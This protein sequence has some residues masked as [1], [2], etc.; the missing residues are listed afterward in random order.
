LI[1]PILILVQDVLYRG[2]RLRYFVG[3]SV[4]SAA[5]FLSFSRGA[6]SHLM[7][8][9]AVMLWLSFIT[10]DSLRF[11]ARMM[12]LGVLAV[13]AIG[14][15]VAALLSLDSVEVM[16]NE[17]ASLTQSYDVGESGRFGRQAKSLEAVIENPNGIGPGQFGK[18]YGQDPH[19]VYINAFVS[20][21]WLG[22]FAFITL[23]VTTLLLGFRAVLVPTPWQHTFIAVY[24]TYVGLVLE[25]FIVDTDHWR[26]LFLLIGL[27][28]GLSVATRFHGESN[29]N[30]HAEPAV[31]RGVSEARAFSPPRL[32]R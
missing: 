4:L 18:I 14:G 21:G 17:R 8:S 22:A 19:N 6:W 28:W 9:A 20:Y 30:S 5:L 31:D 1:F 7:I 13:L 25:S 15:L 27:I 24:A 29:R 12:A 2:F 3:L 23:T 16:F 32:L 11:R 26:H 10:A